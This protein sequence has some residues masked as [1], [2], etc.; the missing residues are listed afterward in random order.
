[1]QYVQGPDL[2]KVLADEAPFSVTRTVFLAARLARA[3]EV[4][5]H[6]KVLHR[7]IKPANIM[8]D[9]DGEPRITDFGL[10]RLV[11]GPGIT[12]QGIFLGTPAYASPEQIQAEELDERSDIYSLGVV[13]F[14]MITGRRPFVGQFGNE[15]LVMHLE[16]EPP[17]PSQLRPEIPQQLDDL[18]LRCL[19][20]DREQRFQSAE[21][22]V[23][24]LEAL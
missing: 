16:N 1:M 8:V 11:G 17:R 24:A 13:I 4:A 6:A 15:V 20:K 18:I 14:E 22:L 3:L 9:C 12:R 23:A 19:A 2:A 21:E 5:H 10:A 7:D